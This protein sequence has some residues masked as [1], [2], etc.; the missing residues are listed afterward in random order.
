LRLSLL[1]VDLIPA[2]FALPLSFVRT[3]VFDDTVL[4]F[5]FFGMLAL[6]STT[7]SRGGFPTVLVLAA[8][9]FA[10]VLALLV[11]AALLVLSVAPQ[12]AKAAAAPTTN[13]SAKLR[14]IRIPPLARAPLD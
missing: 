11:F 10:A 7:P 14:R 9:L 2:V 13:A 1:L 12:P 5:A 6:V 8:L 3:A 4:L